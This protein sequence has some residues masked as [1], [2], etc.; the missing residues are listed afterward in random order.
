MSENRNTRHWSWR[1]CSSEAGLVYVASLYQFPLESSQPTLGLETQ[2][3]FLIISDHRRIVIENVVEARF[4]GWCRLQIQV[5][6]SVIILRTDSWKNKPFFGAKY[7]SVDVMVSSQLVLTWMRFCRIAVG[8][9]TDWN[10][11]STSL[12]GSI[13]SFKHDND[14]FDIIT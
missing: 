11:P 9:K 5:W 4:F 13:V 14:L 2:S 10:Q 6:S 1:Y 3:T 8:D 12:R 7:L